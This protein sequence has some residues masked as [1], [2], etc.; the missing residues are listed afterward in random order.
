MAHGLF[1]RMFGC[2]LEAVRWLVEREELLS[3]LWLAITASTTG[4]FPPLT[5]STLTP[6]E[7]MESRDLSV[8]T[9]G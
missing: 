3:Q 5:F 1:Y 2:S 6:F 4:I 9:R 8:L 7:E